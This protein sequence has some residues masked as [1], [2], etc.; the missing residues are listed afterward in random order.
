M[1]YRVLPRLQVGVEYNPLSSDLSPLANATLLEETKR[2]PALIAGTSSDRIGTPHGQSFYLT[3]S[4][5]VER[6]TGLPL[7]PYAGVTYGTYQDRVR[8]IGGLLLRIRTGLSALVLFDG[9]HVHPTASYR[10]RDH[11]F[12]LILVRGRDPGISYSVAF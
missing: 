6:W 11:A 10:W 2:R 4:K 9:V 3:V 8:P 12:S 7:A 1:T 5:D